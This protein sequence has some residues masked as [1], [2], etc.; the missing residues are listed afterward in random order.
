M[1]PHRGTTEDAPTTADST[2]VKAKAMGRSAAKGAL[3]SGISQATKL[4]VTM[5]SI[6][7]VARI[8]SPGDY[9]VIAMTAPVT[10]FILLFQNL[11]LNQATAQA[12]EVTNEQ[13]NALFFYNMAASAVIALCLI[14]L[15][16]LTGWFYGDARPAYIMAASA[17][18][19]LVTGAA[20]QHSALLVRGM[21]F[22]ELALVEITASVA[23]LLF[24]IGYA[25][26]FRSYWAL[27]L[28]AFCG[29]FVSRTLLWQLERWRP[30]R[31]VVWSS[32]NEMVR[33]GSNVTKF[34]V[35]NYLS[36]NVDNV[37]IAKVWGTAALGLYDRS[38]KLMMFP[39][40]NLN[41]P[42]SRV[43]LPALSRLIDEPARYRR[44]FLLTLR[45]ITL[46]SIPGI[47]AATLCSEQLIPLLLGSRWANAAPIFFW[48]GL[49]GLVQPIM[50][51]CGWL[52]Q[53]SGR[54][55]RQFRW[56]M[57]A[58]PVTISSFVVGLPWGPTGV[59]AAYFV[60][61]TILVPFCYHYATRDNAVRP[62]DIYKLLAPSFAAGLATTALSIFVFRSLPS[63][64]LIIVT[65]LASYVIALILNLVTPAG[66]IALRDLYAM[67][68]P[69]LSRAS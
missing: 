40:T 24:T 68:A 8:L 39:L 41:Y 67:T 2:P 43:M 52:F 23:G 1:S 63:T 46:I 50:S 55:D 54:A 13:V 30:H 59:A 64:L 48:L 58:A 4:I 17:V 31:P 61:Q 12:K 6:I 26:L 28:G 32:I 45:A 16:P 11:G 22:K 7:I 60:V 19:V 21:R 10:G 56:G 3:F 65:F 42:I 47:L 36:R 37:L 34:N 33:F 57:F 69:K 14:V 29:S 51:P 53:S 20:L 18:T 9:G 15:A 25:F 49:A 27:W 62:A 66:R 35:I 44:A 38:Y 5:V